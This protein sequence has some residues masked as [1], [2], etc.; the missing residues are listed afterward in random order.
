MPAFLRVILYVVI[1]L[2]FGTLSVYELSLGRL[3]ESVHSQSPIAN[4]HATVPFLGI[5]TALEQYDRPQRRAA[6]TRLHATGFGWVRQRLDWALLEPSP[7]MVDWQT[8]DAIIHD[9]LGADLIPVIVLDG[10]PAWA[11]GPQDLPPTDNPFAPPTNF[12]NFADFAAAFADR[13]RD[14][15]TFY[16]IWDEP[17]I[18]PHWGNHLIEPVAYAQLLKVA[19]TAIRDA[20]P[21]ATII[22]A[23]LAP[24]R[25]RGHTAID[26]IY[27]LQ[28]LYAAGAAPYFDVLAIQPFGFGAAP[29]DP[30][31]AIDQLNFGRARLIRQTMVAAG[32]GATPVW[33]VRYGWNRQLASPWA[34][35]REANQTQFAVDALAIARTEWPWLTAMAWVIDQPDAP[36]SDPVWGFALSEPLS[37]AF[38]GWVTE[39]NL[40][41]GQSSPRVAIGGQ[42]IEASDRG[43]GAPWI[44]LGYLIGLLFATVRI[45]VIGRQWPWNLWGAQYRGLP[46]WVRATLW[47]LL[48]IIYYFAVWPPLILLCWLAALILLGWQ[49]QVGIWLAAGL[50]PFYAQHKEIAFGMATFS[51]APSHALL[52]ALLVTLVPGVVAR[53]GN[54]FR[55]HINNAPMTQAP[56]GASTAP[57][58]T[59]MHLALLWLLINLLSAYNVWQWPAYREGIT[60]LVLLPLLGFGLIVS[61]TFGQSDPNQP[62]RGTIS[63]RD[64]IDNVFVRVVVALFV[65]GVAVALIGL[66]AWLRGGGTTADG[67][68]RLVGPYY[69]PNQAAFYLERSFFLGLG[70]IGL[71][72]RYRR[73]LLVACGLITI[74]LLLTASRGAL[75]LGIPA[76]LLVWCAAMIVAQRGNRRHGRDTEHST[77]HSQDVQ[78]VGERAVW[79][80]HLLIGRRVW[81]AVLL[82]GISG[83]V[84][85]WLF[86]GERLTSSATL[87]HRLTIWRTSLMLWQ[88]YFW[89]GVGPGGYFWRYPAYLPLG[90]LDEPNLYH[91]HNLWLEFATGWGIAGLLW[92]LLLFWYLG[93][94]YRQ[95]L[96]MQQVHAKKSREREPI[97]WC[98]L[99][100]LA[101]LAAGFAHAQVDAFHVLPD[102]ALWIWF[103]LALLAQQERRDQHLPDR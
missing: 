99:S 73:W 84:L 55:Q 87:L 41:K 32:D 8:S 20:D 58:P 61:N 71:L 98:T 95:F 74:A 34:T 49:P 33:A 63:S 39:N 28:R 17:N 2:L 42:R 19:A 90:A 81:G 64:T 29:T 47:L 13:Y 24:T 38:H 83:I 76:G 102:L 94:R 12:G 69:S 54:A 62:S 66:V 68:L 57:F 18:A 43:T 46:R 92:L 44:G 88:D 72:P 15:L 60:E 96:T 70:L 103:T 101:A 10:T 53:V 35:V 16:Q 11:R 79:M 30:H 7:G 82:F 45:V 56:L 52:F 91:P 6:L 100:L 23:A 77:G 36:R 59:P 80:P 22:S 86:L 31:I 5:N 1:A 89:L 14:Q 48:A 37:V 78:E 50:I 75:L 27:Y 67:V 26:E 4:F 97:D 25:D 21:D 93:R 65:G 85:L 9:I 3:E 51:F 40:K